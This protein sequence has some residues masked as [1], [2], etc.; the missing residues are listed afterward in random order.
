MRWNGCAQ[1]VGMARARRIDGNQNNIVTHLRHLGASVQVLSMVGHGCPD[2]ICGY[3]GQNYLI[4]I[5]DGSKQPS[6]RKLTADE[7]EWHAAWKGQV[8]VVESIEDIL[9]L[10][11]EA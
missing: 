1:G 11:E 10:L 9:R 5:K 2:I 3:R 4:E 7:Q 6:H 8:I